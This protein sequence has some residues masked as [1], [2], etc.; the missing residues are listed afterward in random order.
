MNYAISIDCGTQSLRTLLFDENGQ[1]HDMEK[2]TYTPYFSKMPGWAEQHV[3][4]YWNALCKSVKNLKERNKEKFR[5]VL[6]VS[7]T[8]QRDT[9]VFLDKDGNPLR[10]AII[11]LDQRKAP[12]KN[13]LN[14]F[15]NIAFSI[16]RMKETA[17]RIYRKS[18][19]NWV[20]EMEPEIWGKISKI[21]LLSSYFL[22]KLTGKFIDSK[23]S[24]IGH[25][26][27][28]YKRQS[29]PKSDK[30]WRWRLFGFRRDFLPELVEPC[31]A[32]G[33][34]TKKVANETGL[35]EGI[36]IITSGSD[37]GCETLGTGCINTDCASLSFGTTATIQVTSQ[38]YFE[39][40]SFIPPYPAVVPN[41][42]NPE[43][44]IFRGYWL[45]KWF[46]KEFGEK[47]IKLAEKL[48]VAPEIVLN[49]FLDN[50]PPGSHG[51]VLHPMWT[52]G[53][54]MPNAKGAIIGFGDVHTKGHVYR[55]IIEGINYALRDGMERIEKRER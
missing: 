13:P 55:A 4:V 38:K 53:L 37:K 51:L 43:I 48:N 34:I 28:D 24:Q 6:G 54:D 20:R 42:Y 30:H 39:P 52:P 31:T 16:I 22:Y 46:I 2:I 12:P 1:L 14:F 36:D 3:D 32:V 41:S 19:P 15:E 11:W 25:I 35:P 10:P 21:L 27:F 45:V 7:I 5:K 18:R 29:W 8:T 49:G 17:L 26:P 23:A 50:I 47:E 9:V 33:K 40:I 44:E